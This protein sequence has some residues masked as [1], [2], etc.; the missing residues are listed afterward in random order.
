[1]AQSANIQRLLDELE[2]LP[3]IGPTSAQR[4]AYW[5][6]NADEETNRRLAEAIQ[7]VKTTV[8]FCK[9]C[10]NYADDELCPVCADPARDPS[11]VCVVE[12]P[13]DVN[14]IERTGQFHG[15]YHVLG[16][17]YSPM[18]GIGDE[19]LHIKELLARLEGGQVAEVLIATNLGA[20]GDATAYYLAGL[21]KR[22]G[23][24]VTRLATGIPKGSEVEQADEVTLGCAIENRL[25]L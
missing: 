16:G 23:V 9:R 8:R 25:A 21:I 12:K 19:Q 4:I 2:R 15:T 13:R 7:G 3:G 18:D 22:Y 11:I 14:A 17:V 1:M 6:V 20:E 10:F 5:L 24:K